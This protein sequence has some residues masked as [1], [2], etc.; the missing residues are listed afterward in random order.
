MLTSLQA[1]ER[2]Q[3][4]I[5]R[6]R[7]AGADAADAVYIADA[8]E[9]VSV[10]L[11][12]LEDVERSESEHIGLRVFVGR[13][14]ASIGSSDLSDAAL[15]ELAARALT[16]AQ[17]APEDPYA[18]LAPAPQLL[19]RPLLLKLL[20]PLPRLLPRLTPSTPPIPSP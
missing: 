4:L 9:S 10:R 2:A 18:G 3:A 15:H 19:P 14:S 20:P 16:M 5:E 12:K 6:A 7:K 8:S 13:R 1:Q 11:G 17:G